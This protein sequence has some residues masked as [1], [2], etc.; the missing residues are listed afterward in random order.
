MVWAL[1]GKQTTQR[2]SN[3]CELRSLCRNNSS[4]GRRSG[5][6]GS[7]GLTP[8]ALQGQVQPGQGPHGN[9]N[10]STAELDLTAL[11]RSISGSNSATVQFQVFR[12]LGGLCSRLRPTGSQARFTEDA[13]Y[14]RTLRH[15][16][17]SVCQIWE[18]NAQRTLCEIGSGI[19]QCVV[20]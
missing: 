12:A 4:N 13:S 3:A 5:V 17:S 20:T 2:P 19:V 10:C 1:Q 9:R 16:N 15:R 18:Y 6:W 7:Q 14:E 11:T 8:W